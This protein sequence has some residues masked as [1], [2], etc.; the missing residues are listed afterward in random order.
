MDQRS[1][2]GNDEEHQSAQIIENKSDRNI[3]HAANVDPSELRRGDIQFHKNSATAQKTSDNGG[4]RN[5]T[6][7]LFPAPGKQRDDAG[8]PE[9]QQQD[10]PRQQTVGG[11]G[12]FVDPRIT[13][14]DAPTIG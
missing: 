14:I 5:V 11:E 4:D 6:A 1:D 12:H 13:R 2:S 7:D 3:E 10:K 9:R 8:G